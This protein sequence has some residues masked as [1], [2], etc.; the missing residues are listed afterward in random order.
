M[1]DT[2]REPR[3]IVASLHTPFTADDRIDTAALARLV[4]HVAAAG[5][6]GVLTT[7]VAGVVGALRP[8]ERRRLLGVV[9]EATRGRLAMIAGV[10][11]PDL[12]TS[13]QLAREAAAVGAD[14]V[15]WQPR[16]GLGEADLRD[17]LQ[18]LGDAGT[19]RV[20]LQ[21]LDWQ[22]TGLDA[23]LIA[24]LAEAVPAL[25]AVKV[26]TVAAGPKY[27]AV[28]AATGDRLHLSGGWAAMQMLDGL[29]RGL[30]AFIPSG[31]LPAYV[32]IFELWTAGEPAAARALFERALPI[33]AFSN[34][35]IEVSIQFWKRVRQRQGLFAT[36]RC[37]PPIRP[38]DAVQAAEA[39]RL[40]ER[41]RALDAEI[42]GMPARPAA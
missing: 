39:D 4:D 35:H 31:L 21:D 27:S 10:S 17:G 23:G 24:R 34:Q 18:A 41:A 11:A 15:L 25:V 38:L 12:E 16:A 14:M 9:G 7:A 28:R 37:R 2:L 30:D 29:A 5:C 8:E 32:R 19:G 6:R 13:V 40:A 22:G 26:E 33:L 3:G 1:S 36:T 42:L 20:M